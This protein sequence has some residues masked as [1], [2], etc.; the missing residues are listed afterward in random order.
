MQAFQSENAGVAELADA[1]DSKSI[2]ILDS[3]SAIAVLLP[4]WECPARFTH[5]ARIVFDCRM[6]K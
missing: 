5:R 2:A 1:L 6:A 3:S 4:V